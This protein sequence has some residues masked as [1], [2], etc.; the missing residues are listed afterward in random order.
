VVTDDVRG[1]A[2]APKD[3]S[4]WASTTSATAK[5]F[6]RT[7]EKVSDVFPPL[8]SVAAGL[9]TIVENYEVQSTV[10]LSI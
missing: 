2:N 5:L 9:Y 10:I 4:N 6:L 1:D 7:V 3:K 8:K